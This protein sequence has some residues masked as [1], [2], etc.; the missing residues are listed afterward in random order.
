MNHILRKLLPLLLL[1]LVGF[2]TQN[3]NLSEF[4]PEG[5]VEFE[6]YF[7]HLNDGQDACVLIIKKTDKNNVVVNRFGK[8]VDRNR[9]GIIVLLKN[10]DSYQL[11]DKNYDCFSPENEDGEGCL[12][13][14][15][16]IEFQRGNLIITYSYGRY[17]AWSYT[18]RFQD[19]KFELIGYDASSNSG[20]IISETSINY[21]TKKKLIRENIN[22]DA[23][24]G[25]EVFKETWHD[26][27][28]ESLL[29]LSEMKDIE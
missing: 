23:E 11:A 24:G 21:L 25:D 2:N 7:G 29:K 16:W 6:K 12:S 26:I 22:E 28:V 19:S 20:E 9:R 15:L 1:V 5:Y 8:E 13:P 14:E 10:E 3:T 18:F 4:I 17:G 27:D